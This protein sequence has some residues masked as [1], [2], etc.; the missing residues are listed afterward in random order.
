M[1]D[2]HAEQFPYRLSGIGRP[3]DPSY[4]TNRAIVLLAMVGFAGGMARGFLDGAAWSGSGLLGV[5]AAVSLFLAWAL[6]RDL[7]PDDNP[8]AFLSVGL[9]AAA[10]WM[11][12]TQS[13][14]IP[15]A[16]LLALR[17]VNRS[18]GKATEV[19]DTVAV[20][21]ILG[22]ATWYVSW[23][24][25]ILGGMALWLDG[26][27]PRVPA[28]RARP[29]H[30]W[31]ALPLLAL[32]GARFLAGGVDIALPQGWLVFLVVAAL[33]LTAGLIY[34]SP[35]STGDVDGEPLEDARVRS[36]LLLG[37]VGTVLVTLD[38]RVQAGGLAVLWC[39]LAGVVVGL[40]FLLARR[41]G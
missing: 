10:W 33:A 8:A 38:A 11:L 24:L 12:G 4:P 34:P 18:T 14:L 21:L 28:Q 13:L 35:E 22:W 32:V 30:V 29:Y 16:F 41:R 5:N 37:I 7:A 26:I 25:G 9:V 27:L 19:V 6:T 3:V 2:S 31:A 1:T 36:G 23:A 20:L 40:P 15:V 17:V 39:S